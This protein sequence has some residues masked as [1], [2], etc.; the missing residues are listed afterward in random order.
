MGK[1]L[2]RLKR[3]FSRGRYINMGTVNKLEKKGIKVFYK[4]KRRCD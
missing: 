1:I 2:D 3:G 4:K